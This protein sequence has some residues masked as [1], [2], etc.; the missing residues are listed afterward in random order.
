MKKKLS[1]AIA[2]A[3][4]LGAVGAAQAV[5][6]SH[7][8]EGQALLFPYYTIENGNYTALHLTNTTDEFKAV[9]VRFRRSTDSADVLDFNL[10]LSPQDMWTGAVVEGAQGVTLVSNDTSCISGMPNG[11]LPEA[12]QKFGVQ[13][14]AQKGHIEVI[15]MASWDEEHARS[16]MTQGNVSVYNAVKH[17]NGE[18]GN[19]NAI[20]A[21]WAQGTGEWA[22]E[23]QA[24]VA[25]N[26]ESFFTDTTDNLGNTPTGGLYGNAYVINPDAA[27]ASSFAPVALD[28]LYTAET[29]HNHHAPRYSLPDLHGGDRILTPEEVV[30]ADPEWSE[31]EYTTVLTRYA[32]YVNLQNYG[33]DTFESIVEALSKTSIKS[34]YTIGGASQATTELVVTFP[35]KYAGSPAGNVEVGATFYDREEER[36]IST[37]DDWQLS[38]WLPPAEASPNSL[39]HE[40]NVVHLGAEGDNVEIGEETIFLNSPY[41]EGWVDIDFVSELVTSVDG[42][43]ATVVTP[44]PLENGVPVIGFTSTLVKNETVLGNGGINTYALNFPLKYTEAE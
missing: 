39:V 23:Y 37:P 26:A 17:V 38:P 11:R 22:Q 24:S 43:G 12:G 9:K 1:Q 40:T 41:E 44:T 29:G 31:L 36:V 34:D 20:T 16:A 5:E 21:A 13:T 27:W 6:V 7:G 2:A 25:D 4:L 3:T 32:D 10:Y 15:E 28:N 35:V 33:M 14:D 19:C 42:D 30:I 8:G 18:P